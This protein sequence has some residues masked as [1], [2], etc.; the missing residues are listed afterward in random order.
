M[1]QTLSRTD[2][3][4]EESID[5]KPPEN[6]ISPD[7]ENNKNEVFDSKENED[8]SQKQEISEMFSELTLPPD[9]VNNIAYGANI[10]APPSNSFDDYVNITAGKYHVGDTFVELDIDFNLKEYNNFYVF[11]VYHSQISNASTT[12]TFFRYRFRKEF[13]EDFSPINGSV[14]L[15]VTLPAELVYYNHQNK[16]IPTNYFS[17]SVEFETKLAI[18]DQNDGYEVTSIDMENIELSTP[19]PWDRQ[20]LPQYC[21]DWYLDLVESMKS[22][23]IQ[24]CLLHSSKYNKSNNIMI[25]IHKIN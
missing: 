7:V 15:T 25:F 8:L 4:H 18:I 1:V 16:S 11:G 6:L 2:D 24:R 21:L 5:T 17:T 9:F 13:D 22:K 19:N 10:P 20:P 14:K 3:V 12:D 23:F